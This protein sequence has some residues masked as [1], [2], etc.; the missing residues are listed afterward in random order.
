M[1]TIA[2]SSVIYQTKKSIGALV[3][4]IFSIILITVLINGG[5]LL[6]RYILLSKSSPDMESIYS[7]I[8]SCAIGALNFLGI[9]IGVAMFITLIQWFTSYAKITD[10]GIIGRS[11]ISTYNIPYDQIASVSVE[12]RNGSI[13]ICLKPNNGKQKRYGAYGKKKPEEFV[14]I[15]NE[16]AMLHT[17]PANNIP[18]PQ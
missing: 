9:L 6:V 15:Y 17:I 14:K 7:I 13:V 8:E 16:Q 11:F 18:N 5:K 3:K 12:K 2:N 4:L 1:S 10:T